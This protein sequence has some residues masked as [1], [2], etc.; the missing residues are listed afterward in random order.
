MTESL[1]RVDVPFS[2]AE[3]ARLAEHARL[4]GLSVTSMIRTVVVGAVARGGGQLEELLERGLAVGEVRVVASPSRNLK[5]DWPMAGPGI[6][7]H[8][9]HKDG[10][11]ALVLGRNP[12]QS[13]RGI[14]KE[15]PKLW[16]ILRDTDG[17]V[18]DRPLAFELKDAMV[19]ASMH[20]DPS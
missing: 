1:R 19:Q 6:K 15:D 3:Y 2:Q 12:S 14:D 13:S 11:W 16:W 17:L 4:R 7:G 18:E 20:I 8:R 9:R 10:R 5:Q